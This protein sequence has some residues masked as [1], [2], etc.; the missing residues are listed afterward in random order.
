M[1]LISRVSS[2]T[3]RN[4]HRPYFNFSKKWLNL[5]VLFN[6]RTF[7]FRPLSIRRPKSSSSDTEWA[8]AP[9][10]LQA[11]QSPDPLQH[12][13]RPAI[14]VA[15]LTELSSWRRRTTKSRLSC[16]RHSRDLINWRLPSQLPPHQLLLL[17]RQPRRRPKKRSPK[18][19]TT[20]TIWTSLDPMTR[21]RTPRPSESRPSELQLITLKRRLRLRRRAPSLLNP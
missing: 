6:R 7:G 18:T 8:W 16:R 17:Q 15:C 12:Q 19:R 11:V 10:M 9:A 3:Y 1:G 13:A 20:M 2:R 21:R 4:S 14:S 5:L